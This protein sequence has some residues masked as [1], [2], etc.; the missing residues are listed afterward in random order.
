MENTA[1]PPYKVAITYETDYKE[2]MTVKE[3]YDY[4]KTL[5]EFEGAE[6]I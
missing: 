5:P 6:D 4:L 3:A 1:T 2:N